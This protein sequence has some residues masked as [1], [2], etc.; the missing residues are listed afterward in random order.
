MP[1]VEN[2]C[3]CA[4]CGTVEVVE[5]TFD[6]WDELYVEKYGHHY[7]ELENNNEEKERAYCY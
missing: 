7:L 2:Q 1:M 4:D 5:A 6:E 3:Y